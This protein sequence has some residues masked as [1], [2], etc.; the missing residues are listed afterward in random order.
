M[1]RNTKSAKHLFTKS[2]LDNLVLNLIENVHTHEYSKAAERRF[3]GSYNELLPK[4]QGKTLCL[5]KKNV[6]IA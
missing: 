4:P 3:S 6:L 2:L 1:R 5:I